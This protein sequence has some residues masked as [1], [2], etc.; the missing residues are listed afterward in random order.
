MK[1]LSN[2]AP[3]RVYYTTTPA[4][5]SNSGEYYSADTKSSADDVDSSV[6]SSSTLP[7]KPGKDTST[8]ATLLAANS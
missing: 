4:I 7:W 3:R 5:M 6:C 2:D 8:D 1:Y